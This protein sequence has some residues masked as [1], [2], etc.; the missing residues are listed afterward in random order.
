MENTLISEI[1]QNPKLYEGFSVGNRITTA[2]AK[3]FDTQLI[4]LFDKMLEPDPEYRLTI[5]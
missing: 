1:K 3:L 5:N 4:D 2:S